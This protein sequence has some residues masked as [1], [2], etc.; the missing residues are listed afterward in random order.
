MVQPEISADSVELSES[1]AHARFRQQS[2]FGS[3][4]GLRGVAILA[5]IFHHTASRAFPEIPL[6]RHGEHGVTLFF[7]ISGFL[8]TTL[9]LREKET[10]GDV[11]LRRFY[12]RRTLRIFPLYYTVLGLY[13]VLVF[14]TERRSSAGEAFFENLPYFATY[15]SNYFVSSEGNRVIFYFAWS[16]AVE[17]QFYLV[18]PAVEKWL[19]PTLSALVMTG[20][21]VVTIGVQEGVLSSWNESSEPLATRLASKFATAIFFGVLAAHL[22]HRRET[23][24]W[25]HAVFGRRHAIWVASGLALASMVSYDIPRSLAYLALSL[26]VVCAVIREDH[27]LRRA[28]THPLLRHI[29]IVSYGLYLFHMLARGAGVR[30]LERFGLDDPILSFF[31]TLAIGILLATLS[32]RYYEG[33]FLGLKSRYARQVPTAE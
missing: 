2:R 11:S 9:L 5:V 10:F 26:V 6:L 32:H 7:A 28:L 23:F 16:L 12:A 13:A 31:A 30:L 8:I 22:L 27:S 21:V 20:L 19:R 24:V 14:A 3:L 25:M 4:D 29:G 1:E 15:T 33:I 18:W 17:E